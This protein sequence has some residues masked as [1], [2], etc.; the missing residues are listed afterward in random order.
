M[1]KYHLKAKKLLQGKVMGK[2]IIFYSITATHC[3]NKES[4]TPGI[5]CGVL[6]ASSLDELYLNT[7]YLSL[8]RFLNGCANCFITVSETTDPVEDLG[9]LASDG[10][11]AGE[12][13]GLP[14][15]LP[16]ELL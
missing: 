12:G 5:A 8:V 7:D 13:F 10:L 3:S 4:S 14:S 15:H 6:A 1:A 2:K 11:I 9:T 16:C